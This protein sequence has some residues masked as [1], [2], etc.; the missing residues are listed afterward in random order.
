[1]G[2]IRPFSRTGKKL[3]VL[4]A[5]ACW[6]TLMVLANADQVKSHPINALAAVLLSSLPVLLFAGI[7]LWWFRNRE[8]RSLA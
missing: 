5:T 3:F 6:V 4:L 7:M 8:P 2:R 1:M